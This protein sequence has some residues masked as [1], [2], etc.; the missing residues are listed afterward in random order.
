M[1]LHM[2]AQLIGVSYPT[3]FKWKSAGKIDV[4]RIGGV[5]RVYKAEIH[6][7]LSGNPTPN[8]VAGVVTLDDDGRAADIDDDY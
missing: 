4:V 3:I 8:S 1:S 6:R 7:I 5:N 2:A